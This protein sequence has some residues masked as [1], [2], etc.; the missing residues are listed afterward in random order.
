MMRNIP[1]R[2][3]VE[4]LVSEM[5][6]REFT[7]DFDFL[8]VP[9]DFKTKR[10][11]GYAFVNLTSPTNALEFWQEF[12]GMQLPKYPTKKTLEISMA[13]TQGLE[14]NVKLVE[15]EKQ[16]ITNP[17]FRPMMFTAGGGLSRA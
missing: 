12:N 11:K 1:A 15:K 14:A 2:Y 5:I 8:Y 13:A 17:W 3:T 7:G 4:E 9:M 16:R 10:N 6:S